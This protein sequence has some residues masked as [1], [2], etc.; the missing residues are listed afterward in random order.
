[1]PPRFVAD[2]HALA[3]VALAIKGVSCPHCGKVGTLNAHGWLWGYAESGSE[4]LRRAR[5]FF[6]SGRFRRSG[7][8]RTFAVYLAHFLGSFIVLTQ[9][10]WR[11]AA[12]L[13]TELTI[14]AAW[15]KAS[16][17]Q[18]SLSTGYRLAARLQGGTPALRSR[19]LGACPPPE[20]Q[21]R[22]PLAQLLAHFERAFAA[23]DA[24]PLADGFAA[25]QLRYQCHLLL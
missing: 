3:K 17:D 15:R 18:L 2:T 25:F 13:V 11:F 9:T 22:H 6:C 7:C 16:Q 10:L 12:Y 24:A 4:R 23:Q 5:R 8:G 1:L 21:S 14:K 19:L 20:S